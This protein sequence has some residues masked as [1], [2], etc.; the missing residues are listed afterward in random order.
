MLGYLYLFLALTG[1]LIKGFAGKK[2]SDDVHG[3][4]DCLFVN[5]LRLL[6]CALFSLAFLFLEPVKVA[7]PTLRELPF[8]LFSA[9]CMAALCVVFMFGYKTAAYMYLSIF[10]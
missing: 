9:V 10:G 5:F 3:F 1:G 7:L 8:Y 6:F 4:K 2:I